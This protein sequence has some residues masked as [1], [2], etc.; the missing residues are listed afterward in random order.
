MSDHMIPIIIVP[1]IFV[2]IAYVLK[3]FSDNALRKKMIESG[4]LDENVK[5][6]YQSDA[7]VPSALK[8]GMAL[9]AVGAAILVGQVVPYNIHEEVTISAMFIFPGIALVVYY[10]LA[11][12]LAKNSP[13]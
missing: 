7:H 2:S 3:V 1:V 8:W 12:N 10:F 5:F 4:Q 11:K 13:E 9:I 6:L